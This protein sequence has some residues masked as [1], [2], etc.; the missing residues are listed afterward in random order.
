MGVV[1]ATVTVLTEKQVAGKTLQLVRKKTTRPGKQ[2]EYYVNEVGNGTVTGKKYSRDMGE[3]QFSD[4]VKSY[5]RD[6]ADNS[7]GFGGGFFAGRGDG[8]DRGPDG[9]V[10]LGGGFGFGP[11]E[12]DDEDGSEEADGW[13]PPWMR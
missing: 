10:G 11:S 12:N 5:R 13:T 2:Y 3:Q 7:G 9:P 6:G 8:Q 1:R 4:T